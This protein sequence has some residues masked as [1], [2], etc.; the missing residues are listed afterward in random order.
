M[1][2]AGY[3]PLRWLLLE[4]D[5]SGESVVEYDYRDEPFLDSVQGRSAWV[6]FTHARSGRRQPMRGVSG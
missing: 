6:L 3:R 4:V 1:A 2:T 5:E